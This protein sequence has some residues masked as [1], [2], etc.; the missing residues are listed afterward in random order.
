M[1][2]YFLVEGRS[3]EKKVYPKFISHF[4]GEDLKKVT[5]FDEITNNNYFLLSGNGYPRILSS[6]LKNSILDINSQN[7][8]KYLV[9]CIDADDNSFEE[10]K[11]EVDK[12]LKEFKDDNVELIDSCEIIL[13]VQNRCI[14]TWFLGN[15]KVYK[16]NPQSSILKEYQ[17]HFNVKDKDPELMETYS[18][19]DTHANFHFAYLREMLLERN[20]RY[21]KNH[22]RDV[23]EPHYLDNLALRCK[24]K[25]HLESFQKF[26]DFC[27]TVKAQ[28]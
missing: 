23:A 26:L 17:N 2:L 7:N 16:S 11:I 6:V 9:I 25:G 15:E 13:I 22:P 18:E 8:Y 5:E 14:E 3:T 4:I 1:N 27:L 28:L 12:Y 24:E 10:R 21:S 20:V 19:F